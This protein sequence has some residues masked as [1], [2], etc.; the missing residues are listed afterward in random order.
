MIAIVTADEQSPNSSSL[1]V[2]IQARSALEIFVFFMRPRAFAF[3]P[4]YLK[5]KPSGM[6]SR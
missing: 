2:K 4:T 3:S 6:P 1:S 5:R